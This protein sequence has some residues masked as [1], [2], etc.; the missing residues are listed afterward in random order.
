MVRKVLL[1][2]GEVHLCAGDL[3]GVEGGDLEVAQGEGTSKQEDSHLLE[4][5]GGTL[6][7]LIVGGG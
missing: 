4:S 7:C 3:E 2:I 6:P 5:R 1:N